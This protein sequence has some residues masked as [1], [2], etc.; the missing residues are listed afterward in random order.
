MPNHVCN[1]ITVSGDRTIVALLDKAVRADDTQPFDFNRIIPKPPIVDHVSAGSLDSQTRHANPNRNWYEWQINNWG[2]KWNA[3]DFTAATDGT[4]EFC[5]AWSP[6]I[7]VILTLSKL[8]PEVSIE[9]EYEEE[10][11]QFH[12]RMTVQDGAE[13]SHDWIEDGG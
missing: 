12:G 4:Y 10:C 8:F 1:T 13:L 2:T 9:F 7:P 11:M 5:T 3:Y 6:P